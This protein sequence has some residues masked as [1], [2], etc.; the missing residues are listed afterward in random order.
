M[1]RYTYGP[2]HLSAYKQLHENN[3]YISNTIEETR[4]LEIM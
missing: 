3:I 4:L 1:K 2:N